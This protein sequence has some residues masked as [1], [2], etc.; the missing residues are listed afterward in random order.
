MSSRRDYHLLERSTRELYWFERREFLEVAGYRLRPK[1]H[2]DFIPDVGRRALRDYRAAHFKQSLMDAHRIS[3]NKPVMLK[4]VLTSVHPHE[5]ELA[6]LFS[7]PELAGNSRNHCIP[8]LEVLQDPEDSDKQIIVMPRLIDFDQPKFDTVGEVIHCFRQIFEAFEFMH[9][10]FVAHRDCSLLN[11]VQDPSR[12]FPSGYHPVH[13]WQSA[14]S[15]WPARHITRTECWPRYFV[16]DFGLSRQYHPS[17]G[18]PLEYVIMGGDKSPPEFR[19]HQLCNPFPTDIYCLGNLL[20][21]SFLYS[22][23]DKLQGIIRPSLSFLEPLVTEMTLLDPS[24]R[25]TIGEV[26]ERFDKLCSGLTWWQLRQP[27]QRHSFRLYQRVRQVWRT[28]FFV[29]PI[30]RYTPRAD[31]PRLS[32]ELREFYTQIPLDKGDFLWPAS[33]MSSAS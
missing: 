1:F 3:D 29:R 28:M 11:I 19:T 23:K 8:I 32:K 13:I 4:T 2:P 18:P 33:A 17:D 6:G 16:I 7:S 24:M 12:L 26:C 21:E 25:P 9:E 5:V 30:P 31:R 22:D 20:K 14:T 27:G 15:D 10:N